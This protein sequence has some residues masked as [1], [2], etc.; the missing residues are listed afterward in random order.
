[1]S[2]V[3]GCELS[4]EATGVEEVLGGAFCEAEVVTINTF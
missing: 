2:S 1:M 4:V 3:G